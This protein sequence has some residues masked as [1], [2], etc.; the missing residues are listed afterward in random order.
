[1]QQAENHGRCRAVIDGMKHQWPLFAVFATAGLAAVDPG[2]GAGIYSTANDV[3]APSLFLLVGLS[4]P[5]A[6]VQEGAFAWRFHVLCQGYSL[7]VIPLAYYGLTYHWV[8]A[9]GVLVGSFPDATLAA[10]AMPTTTTTCILFTRQANGDDS[11]TAANAVIGNLVGAVTAPLLLSR[12]LGGDA[13]HWDLQTAATDVGLK[14]L[15][16]LLAGLALQILLSTQV[17]QCWG[18]P[19]RKKGI[20]FSFT[21]IL[22][23]FFYLIFCKAFSGGAHGLSVPDVLKMVGFVTVVHLAVLTG[24]WFAGTWLSPRRRAALLFCAPQKTEGMAMTLLALIFGGANIGKDTLPIVAYHSIQ[25]VAAACLTAPVAEWIESQPGALGE[26]LDARLM[27]EAPEL[28]AAGEWGC[29]DE[30]KAGAT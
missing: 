4:L 30:F 21:L 2:P 6:E 7:L 18:S 27:E 12:L 22:V 23:L 19:A 14:L 17:P 11:V 3:L 29:G 1:M 20:G 8:K 28:P 5:I 16:P 15:L 13:A 26:E 9:S 10:M 24:A 25:M